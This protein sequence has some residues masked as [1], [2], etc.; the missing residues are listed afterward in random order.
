[1]TR[2]RNVA[3]QRLAWERLWRVL[4][5]PP[6]DEQH[7]HAPQMPSAAGPHL[8]DQDSQAEWRDAPV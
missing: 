6:I 5:A 8:R 7:S 3:L 4:L 1:M 2:I